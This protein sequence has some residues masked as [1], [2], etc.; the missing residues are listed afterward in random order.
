MLREVE[1]GIFVPEPND[2]I[3]EKKCAV[4]SDFCNYL[5]EKFENDVE[6]QKI[7]GMGAGH[8]HID[9]NFKKTTDIILDYNK[10]WHSDIDIFLN[11]YIVPV[12]LD[13]YHNLG[14]I[15]EKLL[16]NNINYDSITIARYDVG[17]KFE[18]HFDQASGSP[19]RIFQIISYLNDTE[20]GGETHYAS[21]DKKIKPERGKVVIAPCSFP[22]LHKSQP[23]NKGKKY[24][25]IMQ[26]SCFNN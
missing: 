17:G 11:K 25:I 20:S 8:S 4:P 3:F 5:I 12:F 14:F 26:L 22:F 18:W 6:N 24:C 19:N 10:K 2:F 15:G 9:T 16:N 23:V 1:S 21:F 7:G 13:Y